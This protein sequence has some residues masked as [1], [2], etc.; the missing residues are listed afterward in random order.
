MGSP[1]SEPC[2]AS[3]EVQHEVTLTRDYWIGVTEVTQGLFERITGYNPAYYAHCGADCPVEDLSW[4]EA[5][6]FTN[7]VSELNDYQ[8][9]YSC[10]GSRA[11]LRCELDEAWESPYHCPGYRLPTEA[12]WE[13][14]ARAGGTESFGTGGIIADSSSCEV[15]EENIALDNG[16]DLSDLAWYC[17][18]SSAETKPVAQKAPSPW[19]L[20]DVHGNVWEWNHDWWRDDYEGDEVDPFGPDSGVYKSKRGGAFCYYAARLRSAY[21]SCCPNIGASTF[22]G[23]RLARTDM[24]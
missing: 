22:L 5:A 9:C 17:G 23:M 14:M 20:Y 6:A 1:T 11:E 16:T 10:T 8:S 24:P 7:L 13:Y 2:R 19:G 12:E 3:N 4:N 18:N 15:C 21:R